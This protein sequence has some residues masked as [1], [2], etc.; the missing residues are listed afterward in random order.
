MRC[1]RHL[2]HALTRNARAH[3]DT[4]HTHAP[5]VLR[6]QKVVSALQ[7]VPALAQQPQRRRRLGARNV[8]RAPLH[9]LRVRVAARHLTK[10]RRLV[11][12][13]QDTCA[14]VQTEGSECGTSDAP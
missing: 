11:L 5:D 1:V 8:V 2:A 10:E 7:R 12:R 14:V 9:L 4:T 3:M 13:A 6:E